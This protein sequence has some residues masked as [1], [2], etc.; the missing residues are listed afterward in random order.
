MSERPTIQQSISDARDRIVEAM[1]ILETKYGS[2]PAWEE[3][4]LLMKAVMHLNEIQDVIGIPPK[5][6]ERIQMEMDM[7]RQAERI[8]TTNRLVKKYEGQMTR[9]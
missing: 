5:L 6:T 9:S 8:Q 3:C 4:V 7:A 1:G 2:N